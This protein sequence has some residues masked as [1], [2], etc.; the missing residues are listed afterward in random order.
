MKYSEQ[1]N[2]YWEEGYHYYIEIRDDELTVRD[3][4]RKLNLKTRISYEEGMPET[5][6]RTVISPEDNVLLVTASGVPYE[7][8][9]EL[10]Y[11]NG[12]LRLLTRSA[13]GDE[14]EYTLKKTDHGPFDHILIRDGDYLDSLQGSWIEWRTDGNGDILTVNGDRF[15][16]GP[17]CGDGYRFHVI[18]DRSFPDD[19]RI[20]PFDLTES[21]FPGFGPIYIYPDKL[22]TYRKAYDMNMPMTVFVRP[23]MLDKVEIPAEARSPGGGFRMQS[24]FGMDGINRFF[25]DTGIIGNEGSPAPL[26]VPEQ[27]KQASLICPGCGHVITVEGAR[28]CPDCGQKIKT[29]KFCPECGHRIEDPSSKF[30]T[31]CGHRL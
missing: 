26:S 17:Y 14:K 29:A 2:G 8:A 20:S 7:T 22:T 1:L 9:K 24:P 15:A 10:S 28:F 23:G 3:Y 27:K 11:E 19:V 30:C 21:D 4:R 5:G 25:K 18:S 16:W 6:L 31:E 13:G 12:V